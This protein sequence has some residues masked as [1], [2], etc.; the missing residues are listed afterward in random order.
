MMRM[1]ALTA[2]TLAGMFCAANCCRADQWVDAMLN[3]HEHDFGTVARGADTVF[4]FP[5]KNIYLQDV[6]LVSVHAS[7]GCTTPTLENTTLKSGDT[8]YIVATFN[9]RT[10][11]G[12]H[13][14]TLTLDVAWDDN[15]VRRQ[16]E[17]QVHVHGNIR[18]DVVFQPGAVKFDS[19]D[20][21]S[22]AVQQVRVT[23]AGRPD[24]QITDVRGVGDAFEV[25][26]AKPQR[27]GDSVTYNLRVRLKDTAPAG[28]FNDQV[29]LVTNDAQSP[30]IPLP[31]EGRVTPQ[32]YISPQPLMFGDVPQGEQVTKKILVRGKR[33]FKIL[34]VK[35]DSDGFEFKT[36][37]QSS[38]R[39]I[40]D[41][42]YHA[43]ENRGKIVDTIR[44]LTDL[45]SRMQT[46]VT[47]YAMVTPGA[48]EISKREQVEQTPV[49]SGDQDVSGRG[50]RQVTT[51]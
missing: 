43:Q 49:S 51:H 8:G 14:A 23:Y 37:D 17:T 48:L 30:R 6:E 28:Y 10:F 3:E 27:S 33:P 38:E 22:E 45:G 32:I 42:I 13:A 18:A 36:D 4:K 46:K 34:A 12:D 31:V 26:L 5:V 50:G 21:G 11:T 24:W 16:G 7:C 1:Y 15:G 20:Q 19:V 29:V 25:E 35:S 47:A 44:V 39:H 2:T 40:V 41:V 9:T